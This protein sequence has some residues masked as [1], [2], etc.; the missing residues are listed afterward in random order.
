MVKLFCS[1]VGEVG[2]G[3][4]VNIDENESVGDLKNAIKYQSGGIITCPWPLLELFLA[5]KDD[6]WLDRGSAAAVALD[7]HPQGFVQ[8]DSLLWIK[9]VK[10]FGDN[11]QPSEGEIHVLV[12]VPK[13]L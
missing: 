10:Y 6:V 11:F 7:E 8:M 1:M 9:N 5:K 3:F 2:S 12:V 13:H 4:P